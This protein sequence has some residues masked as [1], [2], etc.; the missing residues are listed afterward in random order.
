ML[1]V[2]TTRALSVE[3]PQKRQGQ[4][5]IAPYQTDLS[6]NIDALIPREGT[7]RFGKNL[8]SPPTETPTGRWQSFKRWIAMGMPIIPQ[9]TYQEY[10]EEKNKPFGTRLRSFL[11]RRILGMTIILSSSLALVGGIKVLGGDLSRAFPT[12]P[13]ELMSRSEHPNPWPENVRVY[14][15][16]QQGAQS[17]ISV[18]QQRGIF[19]PRL[20]AALEEHSSLSEAF[21]QVNTDSVFGRTQPVHSPEGKNSFVK[22]ETK[23]RKAFLIIGSGLNDSGENSYD[24]NVH[25]INLVRQTMAKSY[26]LHEDNRPGQPANLIVLNLPRSKD[27]A[28]ALKRHCQDNPDEVLIY[29]VGEGAA[30]PD[31]HV[32]TALQKREGGLMG[33]LSIGSEALFENDFKT[34]IR[35]FNQA[36]QRTHGRAPAVSIVVD[37][38]GAGSLIQ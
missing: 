2:D 11:K 15:A 12:K 27:L 26:G 25:D 22:S 38:C 1:I 24:A 30:L 7:I 3:S 32:S 5:P 14:A 4:K 19:T 21:N 29:Y 6:M 37:A 18:L 16:V 8:P 23:N 34:M 28:D 17:R 9:Q 13:G 20:M 35:N 10:L 31:K 33:V 36:Q